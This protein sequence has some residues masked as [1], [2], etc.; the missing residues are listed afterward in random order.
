MTPPLL[1]EGKLI[2][3][4][5]HTKFLGAHIDENLSWSQHINEVC[6]KESKICGM[7]YGPSA[8]YNRISNKYLLHAVLSSSNLLCCYMG[9]YMA[10]FLKQVNCGP[11]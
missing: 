11:K 6:L 2:Q 1:L 10:I 3:R 9:M 7:L 8:A 5:P 4:V